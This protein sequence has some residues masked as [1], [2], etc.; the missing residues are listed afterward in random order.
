M[1]ED[2]KRQKIILSLFG[3]IP[4]IWFALIV[5]PYIDTGITGILKNVTKALDNPLKIEFC[6][7][8]IKT[9]LFLLGAY[10]IGIGVYF[11]TR[12]NYRRNEEYG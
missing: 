10:G 12:K 6:K 4:V 2:S 5:A 7:N 8:S 11:S 1:A 3:I 9:V